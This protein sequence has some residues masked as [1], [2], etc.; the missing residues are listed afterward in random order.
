MTGRRMSQSLHRK[1]CTVLPVTHA[2]PQAPAV[3][4]HPALQCRRIC[5]CYLQCL[6]VA[7]GG[8][9]AKPSARDLLQQLR[10]VTPKE[11]MSE[12]LMQRRQLSETLRKRVQHVQTFMHGRLRAA[13][14]MFMWPLQCLV[15]QALHRV[16]VKGSLAGRRCLR[17]KSSTD[18]APPDPAQR[19]RGRT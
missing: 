4:A 2:K 1:E 16:C 13:M 12:L 11:L 8:I 19:A 15:P 18:C 7:C 10:L 5:T 3:G 17:P 9:A 6:S 14:I